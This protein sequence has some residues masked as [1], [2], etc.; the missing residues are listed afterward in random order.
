[1]V[2][3]RLCLLAAGFAALTSATAAQAE[4]S[5]CAGRYSLAW[6]MPITAADVGRSAKEVVNRPQ[7]NV[8]ADLSNPGNRIG[9]GRAPDGTPALQMN[10]PQGE[11][12]IVSFRLSQFGNIGVDKAC[13]SV[14]LFLQSD[15]SFGTAGTKLG[16]G[17]WGGTK[18]GETSG[19]V[20]P[21][22][23]P[24]GRC[25]TSTAPRA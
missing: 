20:P 5:P 16:L 10:I 11:N 2:V 7:F 4:D 15:F 17:L 18:S 13:L 21:P 23:R 9:V 22:S 14:R 24:A 1:M 6:S 3:A 8:T 12:K 19:G 25:A